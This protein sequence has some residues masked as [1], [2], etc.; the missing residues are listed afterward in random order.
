MPKKNKYEFRLSFV[1]KFSGRVL[2]E[3]E[4]AAKARELLEKK[5]NDS[6]Y[7]YEKITDCPDDQS[8]TISR[9][10]PV[11]DE[12]ARQFPYHAIIQ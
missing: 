8:L 12:Q 7:L 11:N 5:W 10:R 2:V 6:D 3:A 4:S 9:A 1:Q